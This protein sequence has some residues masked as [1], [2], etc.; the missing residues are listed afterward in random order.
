MSKKKRHN[1]D[2]YRG[3]SQFCI[4]KRPNFSH[5][6]VLL[7][8]KKKRT[9]IVTRYNAFGHLEDRDTKLFPNVCHRF[10]VHTLSAIL[11]AD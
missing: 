11:L 1:K 10:S 9:F 8:K 5:M 6:Y 3:K 4:R 7:L 2:V